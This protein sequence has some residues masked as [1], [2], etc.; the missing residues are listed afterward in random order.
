ML[1]AGNK[2]LMGV[3][4]L[5]VEMC[6]IHCGCGGSMAATGSLLQSQG[7]E[8]GIGFRRAKGN[9]RIYNYMHEGFPRQSANLIF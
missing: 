9:V 4:G 2:P 5:E 3:S 1:E 7:Q 6:V 8:Q